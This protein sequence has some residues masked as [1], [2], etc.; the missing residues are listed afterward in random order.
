MS[1]RGLRRYVEDLLHGRRPRGFRPDAEDAADIRTAITLRAARPG[2]GAPSE[3]FVTGLQQR[4]AAELA[5]DD[6]ASS[7]R[8]PNRRQAVQVASVAAAAVAVGAAGGVALD[9]VVVGAAT[10][11]PL[12][13]PTLQPNAGTWHTVAA[14]AD[15]PDGAVRAFDVG[16]VSGFVEHG[17]EG[18][19]AV[20]GVC[21]HQGCR[22][23]LDAPSRELVCPCH[24]ATFA[25]T[26]QL[27]HHQL[28]TPPPPLPQIAV[29]VIEGAIQ[30]FAP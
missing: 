22:L 28:P 7:Q 20:S 24:N 10:A 19:R 1:T 5:G 18:V 23:A 3:E 29:R 26:G 13:D 15:L 17:T 30:I 4:L 6:E 9:R 8:R 12:A 11:V 25:V 2:S 27:V 21:T 14:V 16:T